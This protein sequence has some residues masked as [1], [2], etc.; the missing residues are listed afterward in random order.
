MSRRLTNNDE[1]IPIRM[2]TINKKK[3]AKDFF[4]DFLDILDEYYPYDYT[5]DLYR[6]KNKFV[7]SEEHFNFICKKV[8]SDL[9]NN[10]KF[11][12]FLFILFDERFYT[13]EADN[14]NNLVIY[15]SNLFNTTIEKTRD[16][17]F[18]INNVITFF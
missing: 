2:E 5:Q 12:R 1:L 13:V 7:K 3:V 9:T 15:I 16:Q 6:H 17:E 8:N 11:R 4:L 14:Y 10:D 18:L